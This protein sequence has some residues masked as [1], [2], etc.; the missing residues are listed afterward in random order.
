MRYGIIMNMGKR[1][2]DE[3]AVVLEK[4][5]EVE[6]PKYILAQIEDLVEEK[7][8]HDQDDNYD[9]DGGWDFLDAYEK[10]DDYEEKA[11]FFPFD[12]DYCEMNIDKLNKRQLKWYLHWRYKFLNGEALDTDLSY[13]YL[14]AHEL[15]DYS[16]SDSAA[17][18]LS[19]LEK[20]RQE[21]GDLY[22]HDSFGDDFAGHLD[23]WI[24]DMRSEVGLVR[25]E[26]DFSRIEESFRGVMKWSTDMIKYFVDN[27]SG[28]TSDKVD[29][30]DVES[31]RQD[32][33]Y[34]A[35]FLC[36]RSYPRDSERQKGFAFLMVLSAMF[37]FDNVGAEIDKMSQIKITKAEAYPEIYTWLE[38]ANVKR[39]EG[40]EYERCREKID[41]IVEGAI[42]FSNSLIDGSEDEM[43]NKLSELT[44]EDIEE[45]DLPE[46]SLGLLHAYGELYRP[47]TV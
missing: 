26:C 27:K 41:E 5:R 47:E 45:Y 42:N 13:L 23:G 24:G 25:E 33:E 31:C 28:E 37:F 46:K 11:D 10:R 40:R 38:H 9:L 18:N 16:L 29:K 39:P 12:D 4:Y 2:F 3:E 17:V 32:M 15:I 19:L 44:A 22:E 6:T 21:Y 34:Y 20:L 7:K 35:R 8:K 14:F 36:G 43:W 30:P 1:F